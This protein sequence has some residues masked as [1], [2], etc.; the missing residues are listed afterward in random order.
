MQSFLI[1]GKNQKKVDQ[2]IENLIKKYSLKRIDFHG[3]KIEEIR[4]LNGFVSLAL[5]EKT[6]IVLKDIDNS[7]IEA[8]NAFLKNLEEPQEKLFFILTAKN[9]Q[10]VLP[11]ISSRCQT[12]FA[13]EKKKIENSEVF[14]KF[15]KMSSSQKLSLLDNFKQRNEAIDFFYNLLIFSHEKIKKEDKDFKFLAS[16]CTNVEKTLD[17]LEKN[18]NVNLQLTNFVVNTDNFDTFT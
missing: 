2:E 7:T 6:A 15:L 14:E 9:I 11:T 8:M 5:K 17:S 13:S 1:I 10:K 3:N 12:I 16:L 18:G 4:K